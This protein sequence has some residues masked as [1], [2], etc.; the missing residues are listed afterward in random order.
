MKIRVQGEEARI[1]PAIAPQIEL[2]PLTSDAEADIGVVETTFGLKPAPSAWRRYGLFGCVF[3]LPVFI[4]IIYFAFIASDIYVSE[5]KFI[6]RSPGNMDTGSLSSLGQGQVS[7]RSDDDS[8]ALI[9]YIGSR[10]AARVMEQDHGVRDIMSRPEADV[11]NR[12]PSMFSKDNQERF[13][14]AYRRHVDVKLDSVTGIVTLVARAFRPDDAN[15]MANALLSISEEFVN[16]LNSRANLDA[17]AF[18]KDLLD[19]SQLELASVEAKL[20]AYRN[21]NMILDPGKES[22]A[23]LNQLNRMVTEITRME[24]ALGQQRAL[25]PNSPS[26][27]PLVEQIRAYR[28]QVDTLRKTIVGDPKSVVSKIQDYEIL[29]LQRD[30]AVKKMAFAAAQFEKARQ[31]AQNRRIYLQQVVE[32]NVPDLPQLPYRFLMTL[33]IAALAFAIY[34]IAKGLISATMEHRA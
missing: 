8:Y 21:T 34:R 31:E 13:Y 2:V 6:L 11:F 12:Y 22:E 16:G 20:S 1:A 27:K 26:L 4:A 24:A 15:R 17:Q 10:D 25:A 14:R 5:T 23:S 28:D 18:A 9:E 19:Q 33:G 32:P 29:T 30:I 7:A 3:L